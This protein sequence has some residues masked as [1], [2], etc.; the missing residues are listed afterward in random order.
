MLS[1]IASNGTADV[2]HISHEQRHRRRTI[3]FVRIVNETGARSI[4][5]IRG[6]KWVW[7]LD[8]ARASRLI[9]RR[10]WRGEKKNV[11]TAADVRYVSRGVNVSPQTC[12]F[13]FLGLLEVNFDEWTKKLR[14]HWFYWCFWELCKKSILELHRWRTFFGA[15][16]VCRCITYN[17]YSKT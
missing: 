1:W 16:F 11:K 3:R 15:D 6:E 8:R 9:N 17:K 13:F 4:F 5:F 12:D 2:P 10:E 14:L 7:A